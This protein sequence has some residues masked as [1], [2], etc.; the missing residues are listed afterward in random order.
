MAY[1]CKHCGGVKI[2]VR[3]DGPHT[4]IYCKNC[5]KWI[6]WIKKGT[7]NSDPVLKRQLQDSLRSAT[8]VKAEQE[9]LVSQMRSPNSSLETGEQNIAWGGVAV[10][11]LPWDVTPPA[12]VAPQREPILPTNIAAPVQKIEAPDQSTIQGQI[13][14]KAYNYTEVI[15]PTGQMLGL[16]GGTTAIFEG[17]YVKLYDLATDKFLKEIRLR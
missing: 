12:A 16:D 13:T 5:G 10:E 11:D 9:Q 1:T 4:G 6:Q 14:V 15:A 3:Y 8:A 2:E 7:E 17:N